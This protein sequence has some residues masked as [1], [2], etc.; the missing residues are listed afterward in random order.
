MNTPGPASLSLSLGE[1]PFRSQT[2]FFS[3]LLGL[4]CQKNRGLKASS[5]TKHLTPKT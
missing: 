5:K 2:E 3:S 4:R 1:V